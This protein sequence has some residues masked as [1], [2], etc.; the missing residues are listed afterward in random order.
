VESNLNLLPLNGFK[1]VFFKVVVGFLKMATVEEAV[2]G[3]KRRRVRCFQYQVFPGVDQRA[4]FL[5][6]A[7]PEQ[8]NDGFALLADGADD[9]ICE[10]LPAFALMRASSGLP[11]GQ[12][13][14]QQQ[15]SL[16]RPLRQVAM[17]R[18][19]DTAIPFD[20][21]VDISKARWD[22]LALGREAKTVRLPLSVIGVLTDNHY[23]NFLKWG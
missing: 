3:G 16:R 18:H 11:H 15:Y 22:V 17:A 20:L 12:R 5:R 19:L 14:I 4:F 1:S 7:T 2:A 8:K 10:F 6:G 13:R 9:G 23:F 21:F